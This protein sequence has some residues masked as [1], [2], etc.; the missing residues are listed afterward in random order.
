LGYLGGLS[1]NSLKELV[2][3]QGN[4]NFVGGAPFPGKEEFGG[5]FWHQKKRAP[6]ERLGE[7]EL[8]PIGD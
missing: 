5:P 8:F 4:R 1:L 2:P 6:K 7:R 3:S